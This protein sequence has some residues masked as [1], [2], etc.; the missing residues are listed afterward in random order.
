MYV[1]DNVK[2]IFKFTCIVSKILIIVVYTK[3]KNLE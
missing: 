2:F 1:S 3:K